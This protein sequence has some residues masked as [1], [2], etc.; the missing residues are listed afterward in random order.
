VRDTPNQNLDSQSPTA[1]M[2]REALGR[3]LATE[4]FAS[5][6]QLSA[7][8]QFI[9]DETLKGKGADLKGYT[10]ATLALGRP[11]NFD[12]QIDPIVRVQAGRVRQAIDEFYAAH[13]SDP[14]RINLEKGSYQPRF[15]FGQVV[16]G[17]VTEIPPVR[18]QASSEVKVTV[19]DKREIASVLNEQ[20]TL[21]TSAQP[22][23]GSVWSGF[24]IT[25]PGFLGVVTILTMFALLTMAVTGFF[26]TSLEQTAQSHVKSHFP[27][28]VVEAANGPSDPVELVIVAQRTQDA[29]TRFDDILLV[30]DRQDERG[31]SLLDTVRSKAERLTLR[32]TANQADQGRI[33]FSARLVDAFDQQVIWAQE[34]E[35]VFLG[36]SGDSARTEIIR[37]IATTIARPYGVVHAYARQI[38]ANSVSR[39]SDFGCIMIAFDYWLKSE[40]E[41]RL[42]AR[43]CIEEQLKK[44]P[45]VGALHSQLAYLHLDD[46]RFGDSE[47]NRLSLDSALASASRGA[48]L[49][50]ES[51]RSYQALL[52]VHFVRR[53]MDSA[54]QAAERAEKLNPFDTD[55]LADVA[56][57]Y[58]QAG[59]IEKGLKKFDDF[60]LMKDNAPDWVVTYRAIGLYIVGRNDEAVT[61]TRQLV[62]TQFPLAML[63]NILVSFHERDQNSMTSRIN[64]L[65]Q[66]H[67]KIYANPRNYLERINL[68]RRI[69][70]LLLSRLQAALVWS[71]QT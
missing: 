60:N 27:V 50:P 32:I 67:P 36:P 19:T 7:F 10:I 52:A 16:F 64:A 5:S 4:P 63:G 57:R 47:L 1:D 25:A 53:E 56:V 23:V 20:A 62:G 46:Y 39:E 6:P 43:N 37:S 34:F 29:L 33:R 68:D 21:R 59:Q 2:V 58:I 45:L 65:K 44:T 55:I 15:V 9:V 8:L 11:A 48:S 35:P 13:A 18:E 28:I 42:R 61:Y 22:H 49:A 51:A 17:Q 14:I 31:T 24:K 54:W 70:D 38:F 26:K 30:R 69:M 12:P 3:M 71:G 40:N 66:R 41:T